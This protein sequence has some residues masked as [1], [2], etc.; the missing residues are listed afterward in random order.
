MGLTARQLFC[1]GIAIGLAAGIYLLLSPRIGKDNA[2]WLCI[3]AAAPFAA[4]GF[5]KYNGMT[6]EQFVIAWF[7]VSFLCGSNRPFQSENVYY[8]ALGR[9]ECDD[10][11]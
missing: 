9:K 2:S 3:L 6:F 1:S 11:D 10:F 7:K 5:F 8:A 4:A